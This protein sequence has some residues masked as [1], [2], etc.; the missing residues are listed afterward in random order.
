MQS[1]KQI[2]AYFLKNPL[3]NRSQL[4]LRIANGD[5]VSQEW[6]EFFGV[7]PRKIQPNGQYDLAPVNFLRIQYVKLFLRPFFQKETPT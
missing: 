3:N 5:T 2:W 6:A 4:F 7:F 1:P